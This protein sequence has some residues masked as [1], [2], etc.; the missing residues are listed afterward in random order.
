[1]ATTA[2]PPPPPFGPT[3]LVEAICQYLPP[4]ARIRLATLYRLHAVQL[5]SLQPDDNDNIDPAARSR[6]RRRR[7]SSSRPGRP[8][9]SDHHHPTQTSADEKGEAAAAVPTFRRALERVATSGDTGFLDL[10]VAHGL[11]LPPPPNAPDNHKGDRRSSSSTSTSSSPSSSSSSFT[12]SRTGRYLGDL[13]ATASA[14]GRTSVLDWCDAAGYD[15]SCTRVTDATDPWAYYV[16]RA[17]DAAASHGQ[18]GALR[19]WRARGFGRFYSAAALHGASEGGHVSVLEWFRG[20]G[21]DQGVEETLARTAAA[22][23]VDAASGNGH[24]AVLQWWKENGPPPSGTTSDIGQSGWWR[25]WS[26]WLAEAPRSLVGRSGRQQWQ[27]LRQRPRSRAAMLSCSQ[28]AMDDASGNGHVAVLQWWKDS[29]LALR[30]SPDAV[31]LAEKNGHLDVVEWWARSGLLPPQKPPVVLS[32]SSSSS[33]ST[34]AEASSSSPTS[35]SL[36]S[37]SSS[38]LSL[39]SLS[40]PAE[41]QGQ[42]GRTSAGG[43]AKFSYVDLV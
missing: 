13:I 10:A 30:Y 43:S 42:S 40:A 4:A 1:M 31:R 2:P 7:P 23:A 21:A 26:A 28:K 8:S 39:S 9:L 32:P 41:R 12:L 37:S 34:L 29:G 17:V 11:L 15:V 14:H 16:S 25:G 20:G 3:T 6:R 24:V 19:W 33:S 22:D 18:L 5:H 35:S 36:S 38:A 27:W